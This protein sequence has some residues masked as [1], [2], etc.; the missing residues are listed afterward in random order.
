M[1]DIN[2]LDKVLNFTK[3]KGIVG[4]IEEN[5][6]EFTEE[7]NDYLDEAYMQLQQDGYVYSQHKGQYLISFNGVIALGNTYLFLFKNRPYKA[8]QFQAGMGDLWQVLKIVAAVSNS[9]I[10]ILLGWWALFK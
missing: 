9:V 6:P 2:L 5:R 1:I 8:K 10:L 7:E 3:A 4:L